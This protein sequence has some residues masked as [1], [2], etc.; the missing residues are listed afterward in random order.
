VDVIHIL[1][2]PHRPSS[3][4]LLYPVTSSLS[5]SGNKKSDTISFE[6]DKGVGEDYLK[7]D[8]LFTK[9]DLRFEYDPFLLK[10]I[11]ILPSYVRT[12]DD[13]VIEVNLE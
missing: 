12:V 5:F 8:K 11:L 3:V 7:D 10:I 6:K 13:W 1:G 2:Q 4:L 9:V